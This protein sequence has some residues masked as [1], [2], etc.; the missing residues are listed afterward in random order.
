MI[1]LVMVSEY[2]VCMMWLLNKLK[3]LSYESE[4]LKYKK[5]Y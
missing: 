2:K 4:K 5:S 3:V 1:L